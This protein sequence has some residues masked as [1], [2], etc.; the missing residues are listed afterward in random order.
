MLVAFSVSPSTTDDPDS[1][2]AAVARAVR[3]CRD[4]GPPY[5]TTSAEPITGAPPPAGPRSYPRRAPP[6]RRADRSPSERGPP[7]GGRARVGELGDPRIVGVQDKCPSG[8]F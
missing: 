6:R 8:S 5:E 4:S 2:S 1:L 7:Y 3:M